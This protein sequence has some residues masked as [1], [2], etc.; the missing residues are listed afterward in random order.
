[1]SDC[2]LNL[3]ILR[4]SY[5]FCSLLFITSGMSLTQ[6]LAPRFL[7]WLSDEGAARRRTTDRSD[8][9][10]HREAHLTSATPADPMPALGT[11][12]GAVPSLNLIVKCRQ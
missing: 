2:W 1:M 10:A 9:G 4:S 11:D 3:D 5:H 6:I 12:P 8:R 7:R